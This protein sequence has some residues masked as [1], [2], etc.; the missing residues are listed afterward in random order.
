MGARDC[1]YTLPEPN[2]QVISKNVLI[3]AWP[4]GAKVMNENGGT[5]VESFV[6][7]AVV[8]PVNKP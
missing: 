5:T 7:P 2:N 1:Y 3:N 4:N 8:Y 6:Y